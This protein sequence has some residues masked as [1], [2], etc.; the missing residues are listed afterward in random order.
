MGKAKYKAYQLYD[1]NHVRTEG[2]TPDPY[3]NLAQAII[4]QAVKDYRAALKVLKVRP[5]DIQAEID[6]LEI[7]EFFYSPLFRLCTKVDPD[8]ILTELRK[9]AK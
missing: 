3:E 7:E 6:L 8:Y 2:Y 1:P 4:V 5:E 9:E